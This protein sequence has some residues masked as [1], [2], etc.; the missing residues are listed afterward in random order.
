ML[1][2]SSLRLTASR[3]YVLYD[4]VEYVYR[5]CILYHYEISLYIYIERERENK[6]L[7]EISQ[8]RSISLKEE[9]YREIMKSL[10]IER[11]R[12]S[13]YEISQ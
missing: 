7:N 10:Y 5:Y 2:V 9:I 4:V 3:V 11:E 8:R 13:H 12:I 6:Y 1:Y